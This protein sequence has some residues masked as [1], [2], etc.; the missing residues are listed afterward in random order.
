MVTGPGGCTASDTLVFSHF[1]P[2]NVDIG[3]PT[4]SCGS[5][6][7]SVQ[8]P[9]PGVSYLWSTGDSGTSALVTQSGQVI[10][11]ATTSDGCIAYD[12][13]SVTIFPEINANIGGLDTVYVNVPAQLVDASFPNPSS[14]LWTINDGGVYNT[15]NPIHTFTSEGVFSITLVVGNGFCSD[16]AYKIVHVVKEPEVSK[17]NWKSLQTLNVYPNPN[18][19]RFVISATLSQ[20]NNVQMELFNSIGQKVYSQSF[21]E[22]INLKSPIEIQNLSSG[23]YHLKLTSKEGYAIVKLFIN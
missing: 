16:T 13:T 17:E 20:M 8:N 2:A 7:L 15:Q 21:G 18:N 12:T 23:V 14:W 4:V 9:Q 1:N 22:V 3:Q 19:G 10:V 11:Q 5:T 6:V